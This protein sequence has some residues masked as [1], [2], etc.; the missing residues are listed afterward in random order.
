MTVAVRRLAVPAPRRENTE[1]FVL[2]PPFFLREAGSDPA[3]GGPAI[4]TF[5]SDAFVDRFLD[6]V[7]RSGDGFRAGAFERLLPWRDWAEP[8]A[9]LLDASGAALYPASIARETPRPETVDPEGAAI[10][11]EGPH[12]WLRK[13]Y[14][15][16]HGHF[17]VAAFE[18]SCRSHGFPRLGRARIREAGVV[19]RRLAVRND[20]EVWQ[21][22]VEGPRGDGAWIEIADG[23]ME[24]LDRPGTVLDPAQVEDAILDLADLHARL[25]VDAAAGERIRLASDRLALLPPRAQGGADRTGL[26]G[27]LPVGTAAREAPAAAEPGALTGARA[28]L[29][30]RAAAR[31]AEAFYGNPP[32][33]DRAGRLV[34]LRRS[35][36]TALSALLDATVRPPAPPAPALD[37][38][39]GIVS[40]IIDA[41]LLTRYLLDALRRE[42]QT[43][44]PVAAFW[45]A[46]VDRVADAADRRITAVLF[47]PTAFRFSG[48]G[49]AWLSAALHERLRSIVADILPADPNADAPGGDPAH[50]NRLLAAALLRL[51]AFRSDLLE[52]LAG[53]ALSPE[54]V[55]T[56]R[57][58]PNEEAALPPLVPA[59]TVAGAAAEIDTW[60]ERNAP[61]SRAVDPLPWPVVTPPA[62]GRTAHEA[63]RALERALAEWDEQAASAGSAYVDFRN[64]RIAAARAAA[65]DA[66]ARRFSPAG[67]DAIALPD[68]PDGD[69]YTARE[70][71]LAVGEQPLFGL[72]AFPGIA[73][74]A[75]GLGV[76]IGAIAD[77]FTDT[78]PVV[79]ADEVA[80]TEWKARTGSARPRLD[81]DHLY[82]AWGFVRIAGRDPC[83][84]DR[85]VWT[86]RGEPF[87]VAELLD[88]LGLKPATVRLPDIAR[89]MRDLPRVARAHARPYAEVITPAASATAVGEAAAQARLSPGIQFACTHAIPAFT[90]CAFAL[91]KTIYAVLSKLP[92]FTWMR[93]MKVCLPGRR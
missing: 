4:I 46:V 15:P 48:A 67:T 30:D 8:P 49:R 84:K 60:L 7:A 54:T 26:W 45:A 44:G 73:A 39:P 65:D 62:A 42:A 3:R 38:R 86:S 10:P 36:R 78:G 25:G 31:L 43:T 91:F 50:R 29:R 24:R 85:V 47:L 9:A 75:A 51:G 19:I 61:A 28:G 87:Q 57:L 13:L 58:V 76:E 64:E 32:T 21:D 82:A 2:G 71:G 66:V 34:A 16:A 92:G 81:P 70:L 37:P 52:R 33:A 88:I 27:Y 83:E 12:P 6:G 63:G 18:V 22:W 59:F 68:S 80:A 14:L 5:T 79:I 77:R 72:L 11:D 69:D 41:A 90:L 23:A 93:L 74:T 17:H 20:R 1:R 89:L 56:G 35:A 53:P 55:D 40:G